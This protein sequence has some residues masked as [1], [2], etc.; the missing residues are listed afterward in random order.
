MIKF[1]SILSYL[2]VFSV[3]ALSFKIE[4]K[5]DLGLISQFNAI[6][7]C[8]VAEKTNNYIEN[9]ITDSFAVHAGQAVNKGFTLARVTKTLEFICTTYHEDVRAK[10]DSRLHDNNFMQTNFDFYRWLPDKTTASKI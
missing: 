8:A 3:P 9:N 2:V 5:P 1:I 10:R 7:L 6:E 4:P